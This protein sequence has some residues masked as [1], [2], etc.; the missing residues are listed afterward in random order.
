MADEKDWEVEGKR[1]QVEGK[2]HE[3]IGEMVGDTSR[4]VKGK[5]ENLTGKVQEGLGQI[6]HKAERETDRTNDRNPP[7]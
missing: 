6:G 4:Q 2:T 3:F 1:K 5:L 7:V